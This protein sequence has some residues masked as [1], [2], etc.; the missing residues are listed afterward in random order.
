MDDQRFD[1]LSRIIAR[2]TTRRTTVKGIAAAI[3]G[4]VFAGVFGVR[5]QRAMAQELGPGSECTSNEDCTTWMCSAEGESSGFCYCEDPA[6]PWLGC[7]CD[8]GTEAPCGGGSL[9]CCATSNE[10][11]G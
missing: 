1:N 9:V 8:T 5:A 4:G 7:D 11:G 10:P 6:R 2:S 3:G